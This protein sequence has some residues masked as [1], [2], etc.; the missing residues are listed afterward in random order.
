M[1]A[2][3][4]DLKAE[5]EISVVESGAG[6]VMRRWLME[7]ASQATDLDEPAVFSQ[8]IEGPDGNEEIAVLAKTRSITAMHWKLDRGSRSRLLGVY[9]RR[10]SD[11]PP[12]SVYRTA[13]E[14]LKKRAVD[15]VQL[16][17]I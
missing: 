6:D 5:L 10:Y 4:N 11:K 14:Y 9:Y 17:L 2:A 13:A 12:R 7:F 15:R 1:V 8:R 16:S 3:S